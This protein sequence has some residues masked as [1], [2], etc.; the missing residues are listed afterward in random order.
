MDLQPAR[1]SI[2]ADRGTR[3]LGG[4]DP[5]DFFT[6][7]VMAVACLE[8]LL[9]LWLPA[10]LGPPRP[11]AALFAL[12]YAICASLRLF[13]RSVVSTAA[14]LV[15]TV[16]VAAEVMPGTPNHQFLL[17]ILASGFFIGGGER[18][19]TADQAAE[20]VRLVALAAMIAAMTWSGLHKI[21][22]GAYDDGEFLAVLISK[23]GRFRSLAEWLLPAEELRRITNLGAPAA[24][25]GPYLLTSAPALW[26]SRVV[27]YLEVAIGA[28]LVFR[29]SRRVACL[30][31]TCFLVAVEVVARELVFGMLC[32]LCFGYIARPSARAARWQAETIAVLGFFLLILRLVA[33]DLSFY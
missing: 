7:A 33:R 16:V 23:D 6:S 8:M 9:L 21:V 17:A 28:A 15:T 20:N 25:R 24:G 10:Q 32:L 31:G 3:T 5:L 30:A 14:F 27:P 12:S 1:S 13:S 22:W 18:R 4:R 19:E 26:A 11:L 29:R 2:G